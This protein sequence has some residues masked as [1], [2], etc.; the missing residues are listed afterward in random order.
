MLKFVLIICFTFLYIAKASDDQEH[1]CVIEFLK[2][3]NLLNFDVH[4]YYNVKIWTKNCDQIN[5][6]LVKNFFDENFDYLDEESSV[7]NKTYRACL[8]K[9]FERLKMDEKFMKLKAFENEVQAEKLEKIRDDFLINIKFVCSKRF[10]EVASQRFKDYVSDEGGPSKAVINH[11]AL[12]KIKANLIC[13]N[14]YAVENKILDP[15]TYNLDLKLINQ[16]EDDC[17]YIVYDVTSLIMDEWYIRRVSDDDAIQRCFI[18]ILL[19]TNAID[20]YIKNSL[21]SQLQL[22]QEQ[23]DIERENFIKA[24]SI[25]HEMSYKC[26]LNDFEKI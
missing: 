8:K 22:S 12:K 6:K 14:R 24:S 18:G 25:V 19:E 26:I 16:T 9:D 17:K 13:M 23:K 1:N 7:D 5:R 10:I 4:P 20:L 2:K 21:L 11:P 15:S 3:H